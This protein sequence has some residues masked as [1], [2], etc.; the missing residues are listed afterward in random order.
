MRLKRVEARTELNS[1]L[2]WAADCCSSKQLA[3]AWATFDKP[4]RASKSE[5]RLSA[6]CKTRGQKNMYI[7]CKQKGTHTDRHTHPHTQ[8]EITAA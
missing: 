4:Q 3:R 7:I 5:R 6:A 1:A 8:L 2:N